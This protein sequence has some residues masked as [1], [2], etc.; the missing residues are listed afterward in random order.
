MKLTSE[1][2]DFQPEKIIKAHLSTR[3]YGLFQN[4]SGL[5]VDKILAVKLYIHKFDKLFLQ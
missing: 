3:N 2:L 1:Y 4:N 5:F